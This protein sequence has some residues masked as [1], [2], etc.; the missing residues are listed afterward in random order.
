ML[1]INELAS[2][3]GV[4]VRTLHYYDEI[5]L[6]KP[7][8]ITEAGYRLY[9]DAAIET[10]QQVL[11]FRELDFPLDE[12]KAIIS[13]PA[14]DKIRAL[15]NHRELLF[16]KRERLDNLINLVDNLIKGENNMSF[17]EFDMTEIEKTKKEYA[18]EVKER[19][20][21]TDAY[22]ESE[23]KMKNYG[24]EEW[25]QISDESGRILKAFADSRDEAPES[26]EAQELVGQWQAF[27][28]DKYYTCT[29]EILAGLGEMYISDER[30]TKNIDSY[31]AGTADF[32]AK[33]IKIYC[34]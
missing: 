12:I 18:Q 17:K 23:R 32:I 8:K 5:N 7:T 22:I 16:K 10:L 29:N 20:G 11:F 1:K 15:E 14:F 25:K 27:I 33:A 28:T 9:D 6:L 2:C 13:S 24:A 19:W 3:A 26:D 21:N 30:F 31:G 34:K 4:T